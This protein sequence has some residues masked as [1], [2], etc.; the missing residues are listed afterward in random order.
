MLTNRVI[1]VSEEAREQH[2]NVY[3][4]S[5][6]KLVSVPN[7]IDVAAYRDAADLRVAARRALAVDE[8][9]I[10]IGAM[11]RMAEERKGF[12][13]FIEM[14]A[15][16]AA[17]RP[18]ARFVLVGDGPLRTSLERLA[19][20]HGMA[21]RVRFTGALDNRTVLPGIDIFVSPS[22][23]D[24][25]PITVLEAMASGVPVV[26]TNIGIAREA[27]EDGV[28]GRLVAVRDARA[29]ADAVLALC[30]DEY[31]RS[32]MGVRGR[33]AATDRFTIDRMVE[34]V[35]AEYAGVSGD[36][37]RHRRAGAELPRAN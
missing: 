29:L 1:C 16:V 14:A 8:H 10:V 17:A 11:G 21:D 15:L 24:G 2:I 4:R 20:R 28:S 35:A 37:R 22:L 32:A 30:A 33:A 34:R 5:P 18:D 36:D 9:E 19:E 12:D 27:I 13:V 3:G 23:S 31:A 6:T 26:S 7:G 25:G